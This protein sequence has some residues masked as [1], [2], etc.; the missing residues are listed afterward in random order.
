MRLIRILTTI[1]VLMLAYAATGAYAQ[2]EAGPLDQTVPVAD[3]TAA[4]ALRQESDEDVLDDAFASFKEALEAD[5]LDEADILAKRIVE[6]TI[7]LYGPR[8]AEAARALTNLAI[9]Q[10][11]N[12]Q[13]DAAQQNFASAVEIIEDTDDRLSKSLINPLKGL[14][15]AQ[16]EGGR[17][18]LAISTL[19]RAV[20]VTHVNEGPH[21][22]EQIDILESIAET[23]Y[24][25]GLFEDAK[26][27][28]DQIYALNTRRYR[29]EPLSLI[30]PLMRRAT[31]Q[32]RVGYF[33]DE[34][35]S[36]RKI[37]RIIE[38]SLSKD[39]IRLV[40]PLVLLGKSYY[41]IDSSV[42]Q[43]YQTS[44]VANGEMYFKRAHRIAETSE[45]ATYLT[46]AKTKLALADYYLWQGSQGR[47]RKLYSETWDLLSEDELRLDDRFKLLEAP[48]LLKYNRIPRYVGAATPDDAADQDEQLLSGT[49]SAEFMVTGRGRVANLKITAST[50]SEFTDI[51]RFVQRELRSR[52]FR[53][54]FVEGRPVD[55]PA[56][57]FT[58]TFY[59]RQSD[60]ERVRQEL[61][62]KAEALQ[63]QDES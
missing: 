28:Q 26:K 49:V 52:V 30:E 9:V 10:H 4:D 59:Y 55:T 14:G 37:V 6:F 16:L 34:R 7:R 19:G 13:Y 21:N 47:A 39:S 25:L 18:D 2:D 33:H 48:V 12:G 50:P 11:R 1:P 45:Q 56:Q 53:P 63:K 22:L 38:E 44:Q 51:T 36:Y 58:H 43:P 57:E 27:A 61:K 3:E 42:P 54:A 5:S 32:H 41:Y 60:L 23:N 62:E 20:H 15:S 8:S 31:W 35:A 24:R 17:P 29:T 40:E 46:V